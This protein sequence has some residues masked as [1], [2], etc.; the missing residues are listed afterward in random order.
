MNLEEY[1]SPNT[2]EEALEILS[3]RSG[4][5]RIIA[6]GT[7][8]VPQMKAEPLKVNCLVDICRINE[9]QKIELKG[10]LIRIGAAVTHSQVALSDLVNRTGKVLAEA[11]LSI[12][13]PLTRNQGTIIGNIIN[14]QPAADTAVALFSLDASVEILTEKNTR[15]IPIGEL[16]EGIGKSRVNSTRELVTAV[17][18]K[19]LSNF[20]G[21]AFC[22]LA[23]RKALALPV[24]NTAAVVSIRNGKI[25]F[26]RIVVA[27]VA[28]MPL[29]AA[30]AEEALK[31]AKPVPDMIIKAAEIAMGEAQP[32]DSAL[33]GSAGY[34]K[35]MVKVLVR[36]ALEKAVERANQIP[37]R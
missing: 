6:G 28:K 37:G 31:G 25:E 19:G 27:P 11:A 3:A 29:R 10:E 33:R 15:I 36:R 12:G 23:Q 2:I 24:L 16:Y 32:R 9:L 1:L 14:A 22:R 35:E 18:F 13:S 34:R 26:A 30:Q 7:D 8:L 5:A 21:S 17:A 20:Q 4:N